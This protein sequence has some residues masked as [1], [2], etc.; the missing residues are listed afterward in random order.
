MGMDAALCNAC[1]AER[2][3]LTPKIDI[4]V[5]NTRPDPN[6]EDS[7]AERLIGLS[8]SLVLCNDCGALLSPKAVKCGIC[9]GEVRKI[10]EVNENQETMVV[11][12]LSLEGQLTLCS[13][14]GAFVKPDAVN[15]SICSSS[16]KENDG[17]WD[18]GYENE[19]LKDEGDGN[20]RFWDVGHEN[21]GLKDEGDGNEGLK[22]V[23][24]GNEDPRDVGHEDGRQRYEGIEDHS[25]WN[26]GNE[27]AGYG[28]D[29]MKNVEVE[30]NLST[31]KSLYLC[32][33]CSAS[34]NTD[35]GLCPHCRTETSKETPQRKSET[36]RQV[37]KIKITPKTLKRS[38]SELIDDC[39]RLL[40]KKAVAIKILGRYNQALQSL[41]KA[42]NLSPED[43]TI[44]LYKADIHYE[45]EQFKKSM[46]L[47]KL[48]LE[49]DLKNPDIWNRLGNSLFRL[50]HQ[51][52]SLLCYE[53]ALRL[54]E[55]NRDAMINKGYL[56]MRMKRY[57]E[58]KVC[59]KKVSIGKPLKE[60]L[61][62]TLEDLL[63]T[64]S[65]SS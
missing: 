2:Q 45:L 23:G 1:G 8:S 37:N 59:A 20:D 29:N 57:D 7:P 6:D 63:D 26:K 9:G 22:D 32:D 35:A 30:S 52:E 44:M 36:P 16:L 48:V 13:N 40:Y 49:T 56:L 50:G 33:K 14:C 15:C 55:N 65:F 17:H 28:D 39:T 12:V 38:K 25:L 24:H 54:D 58:A 42:L 41:T 21:E 4:S 60:T 34:M 10:E 62:E 27:D 5:G 11:E 46:K 47:Y 53:K 19:G 51:M 18:V 3:P 31:E 61:E 43:R 64:L